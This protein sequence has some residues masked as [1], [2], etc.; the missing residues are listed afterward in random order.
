MQSLVVVLV[1]F[2]ILGCTVSGIVMSQYVFAFLPIQGGMSLARLVHM[3][4][5]Y[6]S[7][8]LMSLHLGLHWNMILGV[9]RKAAGA[10]APSSIRTL[11]LRLLAAAVAAYG[12]YAFVKH[13][14]VNYLFL[15]TM[16]VFFDY[17]QPPLQFLVE[18]LAMMGLFVIFAYFINKFIGKQGG[19]S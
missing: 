11:I 14:L 18:Y 7:F 6:W 10:T 9:V 12:V 16:F 3:V 13:R 19:K 2:S 15:R 4:C 5:V 17:E 8:I 1:F